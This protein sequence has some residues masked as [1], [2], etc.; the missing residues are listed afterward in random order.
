[1]VKAIP[2]TFGTE[3]EFW[4]NTDL[5][6]LLQEDIDEL[7]SEPGVLAEAFYHQLFLIA[8]ELQSLFNDVRMDEQ[9]K[10]LVQTLRFVV[11]GIDRF[12]ELKPVLENLG[13]RH[14]EYG[15]EKEHY[16]V[17]VEA[18]IRA[19]KSRLGLEFTKDR[20]Q[21]W[22]FALRKLAEAMVE[23]IDKVAA[24]NK[25]RQRLERVDD[26]QET[27]QRTDY[28]A[29][30]RPLI[31]AI[32]ESAYVQPS[33]ES[34]A[35]H[36]TL[37]FQGGPKVKSAPLQTIYQLS[38]QHDIPHVAECGGKAKCTTCRVMI[39]EGLE[40]CLPRN[41]P[42]RAMAMR[43]GFLP[44]I[45]LACQTRL[46]GPVTCRRLVVDKIDASQASKGGVHSIGRETELA[47]MF[48]DIRGF[49]KL[50]GEHVPY[51]IVHA[52]NRY[53]GLVCEEIDRHDGYVDKY[54]GDGLMALFG[55]TQNRDKHPCVEALNA[56]IAMQRRMPE[57]NEYLRANLQMTF[58]IGVGI[59]F[60]TVVVGELGFPQKKQFTAIG[61]AVNVSARI[62]G[63]CK[64][65]GAGI[66]VSESV[67]AV[68]SDEE[69]AI[70][71]ATEVTLAGKRDPM[72]VHSISY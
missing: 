44:Q 40:N 70:G 58:D 50:S 1:M 3:Q 54:M 66:L 64:K 42:E 35:R 71:R 37:T 32:N 41:G 23:G 12:E 49:T 19:L 63:Q 61:D 17:A 62:E 14:V 43:K 48:A 55:L 68:L 31:E 13:Y 25:T 51:D 72:S 26:A 5:R 10:M 33:E 24:Q 16:P 52:L 45:R 7:S 28:L 67:R 53:F 47:V 18:F 6:G 59:H 57:L 65:L 30:F 39:L 8:P 60:G 22:C 38:V 11:E 2:P 29:R 34:L 9:G 20:E 27:L 4:V 69:F 36:F 46:T 21:A 15:V 56:A